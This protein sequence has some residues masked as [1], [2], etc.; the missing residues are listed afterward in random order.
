MPAFDPERSLDAI[1]LRMLVSIAWLL[2]VLYLLLLPV[3]LLFDPRAAS[4]SL[5]TSY[6]F[7]IP[8]YLLYAVA[9]GRVRPRSHLVD[10]A[11]FLIIAFGIAMLVHK[12]LILG[13]PYPD[14]SLLLLFTSIVFRRTP[15]FLATVGAVLF[16]S[17]L[18]G[19]ALGKAPPFGFLI[20]TLFSLV[21]AL[22]SH[23]LLLA[24]NQRSAALMVRYRSMLAEVRTLR[25]LIPICSYCKKVRHD[26]GFWEQVEGFVAS[27][28]YARFSHGICPDCFPKVQAEFQEHLQEKDP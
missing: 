27:R 11:G 16:P 17:L 25:G 13:D 10:L 18:F 20:N 8:S 21:L 28:S 14:S 26:D 24:L 12:T 7:L 19:L 1:Y 9:F 3:M 22:L 5:I 6:A 23:R 4:R 2:A 15:A